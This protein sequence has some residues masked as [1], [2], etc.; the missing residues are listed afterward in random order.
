M[1]GQRSDQNKVMPEKEINIPELIAILSNPA[2]RKLSAAIRACK[3][4][5]LR[6][7]LKTK[8]PYFTPFG[9]FIDRKNQ[10]ILSYNKDI[11][12]VDINA[13]PAA[14]ASIVF[15]ILK[16]NARFSEKHY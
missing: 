16:N 1:V 11:L 5:I 13:I 4:P 12:A 14:E 9:S 7:K 8:L 15:N 6:T 3:D 10:S 2:T